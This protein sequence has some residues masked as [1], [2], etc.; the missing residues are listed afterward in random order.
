M[1][2]SEPIEHTGNGVLNYLFRAK[3]KENSSE[4]RKKFDE[5]KAGFFQI[6]GGC[7]FDVLLR[8]NNQ[9]ELKLCNAGGVWLFADDCGLGFR[10]LLIMLYFGL[11]AKE[12]VILIEE[13][14]NHLHPE[15][16]RA[17]V[18]FL[19]AKSSKQFFLTT[20]SSVFLSTEFADR[21][22]SCRLKD[23][24]IIQNATSKAA[25]LTELGYSISDNLVSDLIIL[26]EGPKDKP[27]LEEFLSKRGL[28]E[29]FRIKI[30]PL[31]GDI[32]AQLDLSVF[33]ERNRVLALIDSDPG[34][35]KVRKSF[36]AKCKESGIL[37]QQLQRY[38]LENYFTISAIE[39]VTSQKVPSGIAQL[40]PNKKVSA[41]IGFEVKNN[42]R[43]IAKEMTLQDI[44]ATDLN[45]F[46][47]TAEKI[48]K[49]SS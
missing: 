46:L 9:V 35:D 26:C 6:T 30:W 49:G 33:E 15:I 7:D 14:E 47:D 20:H 31:G 41:Q 16:Q 45:A 44:Q 38:A 21:V 29:K 8:D 18:R 37:V 27:A 48:L 17:L 10:D 24:V 23:S 12:D 34:S 32:M 11:A 5:I 25:L 43:K 13:P 42:G 4:L 28:L 2:A 39:K 40:D 36:V 3:N 19:R 1:N 22:F